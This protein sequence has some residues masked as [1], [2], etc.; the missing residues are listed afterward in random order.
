[1]ALVTI[2]RSPSPSNSPESEDD[3][4]A[5]SSRQRSF[6]ENYFTVKG[7]ALILPQSE[8]S[9]RSPQSNGGDIQQHLQQ[10][11]YL[12]RPEDT[13]KVAV[14]LESAYEIPLASRYM[15]VVCCLGKLDTEESIMLGIDMKDKEAS[16][17]LVLPIWANSKIT[18]DGDGGFGVNS[19]GADYLFKPVSVQAMC[20]SIGS[21]KK[22]RSSAHGS[23]KKHSFL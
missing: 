21:A 18:L 6:S 16:I 13:I 2:Q 14:K 7:A 3:I 19:E 9:Q 22:T 10:M 1:M 15:V 17:G 23:S 11:I 12:L 20:S 4:D 5:N 8:C